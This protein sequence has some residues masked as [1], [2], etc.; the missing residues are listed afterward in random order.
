FVERFEAYA[1]RAADRFV[2]RPRCKEPQRQRLDRVRQCHGIV[3]SL[4]WGAFAQQAGL[5]AF[6]TDPAA[7]VTRHGAR[8]AWMG[9]LPDQRFLRELGQQF[10][11][12]KGLAIAFD[13]D[14]QRC[15]ERVDAAAFGAIIADYEF[16]RAFQRAVPQYHRF[17][18]LARVAFAE[19]CRPLQL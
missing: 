16:A 11:L 6:Q 19:V 18:R 4:R 5:Y 2:D 3:V 15:G 12:E 14:A 8:A 17:H 10:E 9:D 7:Q 13:S 1:A